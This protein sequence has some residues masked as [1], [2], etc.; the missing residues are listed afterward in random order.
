MIGAFGG[1]DHTHAITFLGQW[2]PRFRLV[3]PILRGTQLIAIRLH[4]SLALFSLAAAAT[5]STTL[6]DNGPVVTGLGNGYSGANT[7]ATQT[8]GTQG[9]GGLQANPG[10]YRIIEEFEVPEGQ[11]WTLSE[12]SVY[13]FHF[14]SGSTQQNPPISTM[15]RMWAGLHFADPER[16]GA[17]PA[18]GGFLMNQ[19][20][21]QS[22][23]WSGAYRV[24][25]TSL[26]T[27][28]NAM[29]EVVG[30]ATDLTPERI[31]PG[32][33]WLEWGVRTASDTQFVYSP[34]VTPYVATGN[35]LQRE[36]STNRFVPCNPLEFPFQLRGEADDAAGFA[37]VTGQVAL[38]GIDNLNGQRLRIDLEQAGTIV[39]T[40]TVTVDATG[41]FHWASLRRGTYDVVLSGTT[42]L[43]KRIAD[44]SFTDLG[45][46]LP[47]MALANGDIDGDNAV[48][49]FDY[50]RLSVAFDSVGPNWN[51][52]VVRKETP[53]WW[54][55]A[56][57]DTDNSVSVFDF[58]ILSRN[59]DLQGD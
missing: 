23:R 30:N 52:G 40:R 26:L 45:V 25:P 14:V 16:T 7:S 38:D 20:R 12:M 10:F 54:H 46:S 49:V 15:T 21:F 17:Q 2:S 8:I 55:F 19:N 6:F 48:T 5:A 24:I 27:R 3:L 22:T 56:D 51:Y 39:E 13:A 43:R 36:I 1:P 11:S 31:G 4:H 41:S 53:T 9:P 29:M 35:G 50:D 33:Y 37:S 42:C 28:N 57:L 18:H 59:F 58:D 44:V 34:L 47:F 32:T